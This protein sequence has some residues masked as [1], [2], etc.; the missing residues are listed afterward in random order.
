MRT[1]LIAN[2]FAS[3]LV[4][5]YSSLGGRLKAWWN[6]SPTGTVTIKNFRLGK[7]KLEAGG[8]SP[9]ND[10]NGPIVY[11]GLS[12]TGAGKQLPMCAYV[13]AAV[14]EIGHGF[15]GFSHAFGTGATN[16]PTSIMDYRSA[17]RQGAGFNADQQ[18]IIKA[19]I[20]GGK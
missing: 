20:W 19:S 6:D 17:Y 9:S 13:N 1:T 15:F 2:G 16:D 11:N 18:A 7:D 10:P 8:Y 4:V 14:H 12:P 5:E 3:N